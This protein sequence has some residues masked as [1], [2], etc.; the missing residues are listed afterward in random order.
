MKRRVTTP[1]KTTNSGR[2]FLLG[3]LGAPTPPSKRTR[4][5]TQAMPTRQQA[6]CRLYNGCYI[7]RLPTPCVQPPRLHADVRRRSFGPAWGR[8]DVAQ[9]LP[10]GKTRASF[11]TEPAWGRSRFV[12][13]AVTHDRSPRSSPTEGRGPPS[14][15][16]RANQAGNPGNPGGDRPAL[17]TITI[18]VTAAASPPS[19]LSPRLAQLSPVHVAVHG[20]LSMRP[21]SR[22]SPRPR[23][24]VSKPNGELSPWPTLRPD[25]VHHH[26]VYRPNTTAERQAS[27]RA[28][29]LP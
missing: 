19:L 24:P 18:T 22:L 27:R 7:R 9:T 21:A 12:G 6:D 28:L 14:P 3:S 16:V 26:L 11:R 8:T 25:T 10:D 5:T 15:T 23:L 2:I 13:T 4:R 1:V 29:T 17:P 20:P